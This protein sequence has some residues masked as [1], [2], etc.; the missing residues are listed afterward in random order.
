MHLVLQ[1]RGI[2]QGIVQLLATSSTP[3]IIYAGS[4][5]AVDLGIETS[6]PSSAIH[7]RKLDI[8]DRSTVASLHDEIKEKHGRLDIL[9]NNAGVHLDNHYNA[10]NA[11]QTINTNYRGIVTVS[12]ILLNLL[13]LENCN[14]LNIRIRIYSCISRC[15]KLSSP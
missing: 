4:R 14:K 11:K 10:E 7:Y 6:Q 2:G 13:T 9:I 3:Y 5:K 15:R 8:T 1:S 12:N